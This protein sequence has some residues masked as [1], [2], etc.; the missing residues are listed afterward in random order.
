[1]DPTDGLSYLEPIWPAAGL[2]EIHDALETD[3][4]RCYQLGLNDEWDEAWVALYDTTDGFEHYEE[5]RDREVLDAAVGTLLTELS[6]AVRAVRLETA[7]AARFSAVIKRALANAQ[8][9]A[10]QTI[11]DE[12]DKLDEEIRDREEHCRCLQEDI[13]AVGGEC[14][15]DGSECRCAEAA[16]GERAE[17]QAK[18][19]EAEADWETLD[20]L[21]GELESLTGDDD[22]EAIVAPGWLFGLKSV[23]PPVTGR[24]CACGCGQPV[25]SPRPEAKYAT[26]ACRV[27]AHRERSQPEARRAV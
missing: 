26:G 20:V 6:D 16:D 11:L 15:C 18:H 24:L 22:D 14:I 27:R 3:R 17:L 23:T 4:E 1:M 5:I 10:A 8:G 2:P 12:L 13:A 7:K 19:A 21:R 9:E 25:T